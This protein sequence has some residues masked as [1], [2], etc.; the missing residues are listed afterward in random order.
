M[1]DLH[2]GRTL[3]PFEA[4]GSVYMV[5]LVIQCSASASIN[6]ASKNH[7]RKLC[8]GKVPSSPIHPAPAKPNFDLYN[9]IY[10]KQ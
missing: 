7:G 3:C 9:V 6:I 8:F 1:I 2:S 10:L 5:S 4:S